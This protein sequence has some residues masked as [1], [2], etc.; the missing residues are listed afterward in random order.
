M[1]STNKKV[2]QFL[3]KNWY[4]VGIILVLLFIVFKKD[5][6]F[7]IN[8]NTPLQPKQ[9]EHLP[10]K[11]SHK[12][13]KREL[14]TDKDTQ[15]QPSNKSSVLDQLAVPFWN[16]SSNGQKPAYLREL[17]EVDDEKK[18]AFI[19]RFAHV[20]ITE[21]QK[22]GIPASVI[23]ANALLNSWSGEA[24]WAREGHNIFQLPCTDD[25]VG[26]KADYDGQCMRHYENAW[27]SFR[28][29]SLYVTTGQY[30]TQFGSLSKEDIPQWAEVL[31]KTIFDHKNKYE[32]SVL[33]VINEY[34]LNELDEE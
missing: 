28:D 1:S 29:H 4:K 16:T 20:A 12:K 6:S 34:M 5:F 8:L 17:M 9:E 27:T 22:Y 24:P 18:N 19:K 14:Y 2:M 32:E 23:M 30:N 11:Q 26:P 13:Q 25:W 15:T 31:G 3:K 7:R 33:F 10:V 21:S